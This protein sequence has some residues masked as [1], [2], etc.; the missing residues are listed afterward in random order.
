MPGRGPVEV[1]TVLGSGVGRAGV[2]VVSVVIVVVFA[3][4][5]V[6][7]MAFVALECWCPWQHI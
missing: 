4:W 5:I 2:S 6:A 3:T 7:V 1:E